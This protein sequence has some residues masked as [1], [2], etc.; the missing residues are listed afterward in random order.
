VNQFFSFLDLGMNF[1]DPTG[2]Y[3][4]P[5]T[6]VVV[7]SPKNNGFYSGIGAGYFRRMTNRGG[8]PYT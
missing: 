6:S 1:Y 4:T 3:N 2:K 5:G 8:G 7:Y